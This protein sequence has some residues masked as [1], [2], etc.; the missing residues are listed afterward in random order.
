M[1]DP[2]PGTTSNSDD[3]AFQTAPPRRG[4]LPPL[5]PLSQPADGESPLTNGAPPRRRVPRSV[6]SS[7]ALGDETGKFT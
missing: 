6:T 3:N 5:Q 2:L 7:P 4:A 1:A